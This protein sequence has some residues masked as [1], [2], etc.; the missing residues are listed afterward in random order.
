M[1]EIEDDGKGID[2]NTLSAIDENSFNDKKTHGGFS[3][4]GI[5]NVRERLKIHYGDES[6]VIF[7]SDGKSFTKVSIILPIS[8]VDEDFKL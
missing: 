8:Y 3:S 6:A 5:A 1:I 7:D 2:L 4:I